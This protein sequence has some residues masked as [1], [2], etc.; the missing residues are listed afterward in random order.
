METITLDN[1]ITVFYVEAA[2]FTDG[3]LEAHESLHSLIPFSTERKYFGISRPENGGEIRYKAC[4]EEM[5]EGE[6]KAVGCN[7][8]VLRKGNYV[9]IT[10]NDYL[11][12]LQSVERTFSQLLEH[13]GLDPQ[14]Y[15]VEWYITN[16]DMRCMVRLEN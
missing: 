2:S 13:P 7:T 12:D 5:Y 14:G 11:K 6:G 3:I 15:C 1:D 9:C 10:L 8:V 4:A 16:K